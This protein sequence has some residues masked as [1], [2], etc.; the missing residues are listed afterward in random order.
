M[1]SSNEFRIQITG[2]D[3]SLIEH[4]GSQPLVLGWHEELNVFV[5]FD[6]T[7]HQSIG[8]SPSVQV[9][10]NT[11]EEAAQIG[12]AFHVR[13]NGEIAVV[14]TPDQFIT[15]VLNQERFHSFGGHPQDIALLTTAR[16]EDIS[17]EE[18]VNTPH[19]RRQA[20]RVVRQLVRT[21]SFRSR[22]LRA[23]QERCAVC[24]IQLNLVQA[25]HIIPVHVPGSSDATNNGLALCPSHHTAYDTGLVAIAPDYHI[26]V[27]ET[28]LQELRQA[29]LNDRE[30]LLL[31][32]VCN[33]IWLPR[34]PVDRPIPQYLQEG[35]NIRGWN[36]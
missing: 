20:I 35:M 31:Q 15:Y 14:F 29:N 26:V 11:F 18:L 8:R 1:R 28:R 7:R 36:L 13:K 21:R 10:L 30:D 22:V 33:T 25:A 24:H 27:H 16:E 23:Y 12:I 19:D 9:G 17:P 34:N 4:P 3:S 2:F 5:A 6:F 32:Y